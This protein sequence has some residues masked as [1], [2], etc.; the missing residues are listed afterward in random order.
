MNKNILAENMRRFG[1]KNLP[2]TESTL[3]DDDILDIIMTYT[4]DPDAAEAALTNY[5]ETGDFGDNAIQANVTRDPRW[6]LADPDLDDTNIDDIVDAFTSM[7]NDQN[8]TEQ[9][10]ILNEGFVWTPAA[11]EG[12]AALGAAVGLGPLLSH[13]V[14]FGGV[15]L[16]FASPTI[17]RK[18][19]SLLQSIK[20]RKLTSPA[21]FENFK[22]EMIETVKNLPAGQRAYVTRSL[23]DIL[24]YSKNKEYERAFNTAQQLITYLRQNK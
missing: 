8:L 20:G 23:N 9:Q 1:T 4:K 14:L 21:A 22:T 17:K 3:S 15:A 24:K 10:N 6:T 19:E 11:S 18:Y 12:V 2:L 7:L 5:R 16:A 13:F